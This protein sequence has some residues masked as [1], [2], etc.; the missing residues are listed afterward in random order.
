MEPSQT[1]ELLRRAGKRITRERMLVLRLIHD[2]AH[3]DA[4]ELYRLAQR[5]NPKIN[6]STIYRTAKLLKAMGLVEASTLGEDHIHYEARLQKHYHLIC[7]DCGQ[8]R[9]IPPVLPV[10]KLGTAWGFDVVGVKVEL[11]GYCKTCRKSHADTT[12][13]RE[14]KAFP[15]GN[16]V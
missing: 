7:Q 1:I 4:R 16:G 3:L 9:E 2:H 10:E 15:E 11:I 8:V 5:E 14:E 13:N 12:E 6:L